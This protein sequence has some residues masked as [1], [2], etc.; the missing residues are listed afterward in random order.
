ML[1]AYIQTK[2]LAAYFAAKTKN[3]IIINLFNPENSNEKNKL[4]ITRYGVN[5]RHS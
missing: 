1:Y 5:F 4:V 3:I 2:G